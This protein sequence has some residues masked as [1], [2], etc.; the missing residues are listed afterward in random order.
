MCVCVCLCVFV[1]V[2]DMYIRAYI[3]V[4]ERETERVCVCVWGGCMRVE[5]CM[6]VRVCVSHTSIHVYVY[7]CIHVCIHVYT[8][9]CENAYM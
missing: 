9:V 5:V 7:V 8:H 3:H 4:C 2:C 6:C 1:Y